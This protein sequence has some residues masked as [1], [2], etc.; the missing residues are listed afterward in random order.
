MRIFT[1]FTLPI[2][3]HPIFAQIT[4]IMGIDCLIDQTI[5]T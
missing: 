4:A 1:I 3:A 2:F 5:K